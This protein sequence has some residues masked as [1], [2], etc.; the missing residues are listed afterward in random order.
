M[1]LPAKVI[2]GLLLAL[3]STSS[4]FASVEGI[5]VDADG[6]YVVSYWGEDEDGKQVWRTVKF[7]PANKIEPAAS[8]K[9]KLAD[10]NTVEYRYGIR[11]GKGSRQ[12][13]VGLVLPSVNIEVDLP[14]SH[15]PARS[16]RT[17]AVLY[18]LKSALIS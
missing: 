16:A 5:N 4:L 9:F 3:L 2:A 6:N 10:T 14:Q 8:S 1:H 12:S 18:Q 13:L 11:S 15:S 7:V 17:P